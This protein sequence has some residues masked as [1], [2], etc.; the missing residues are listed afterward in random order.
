M[1]DFEW[2]AMLLAITIS[3]LFRLFLNYNFN[4]VNPD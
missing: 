3:I 1:S 2:L 4:A